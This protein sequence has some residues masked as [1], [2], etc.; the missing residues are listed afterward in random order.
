MREA[1]IN[2]VNRIRP[3]I[4]AIGLMLTVIIIVDMWRGGAPGAGAIQIASIAIGGLVALGGQ[5]LDKEKE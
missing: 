4:L 2:L 1:L 5:I 3:N